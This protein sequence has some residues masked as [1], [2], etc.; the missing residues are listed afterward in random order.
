MSDTTPSTPKVDLLTRI[1]AVDLSTQRTDF[2]F[3]PMPE[4]HIVLG[5][6][7]P[8][9]QKAF[10]LGF[11]IAEEIVT[12]EQAIADAHKTHIDLH[13]SDAITNGACEEHHKRIEDLEQKVA[14]LTLIEESVAGLFTSMVLDEF[15]D[16]TDVADSFA[17]NEGFVVSKNPAT[18]KKRKHQAVVVGVRIVKSQPEHKNDASQSPEE[19]PTDPPTNDEE[20]VS[21]K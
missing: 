5:T 2:T 14:K 21:E 1:L 17:I 10:W 11:D 7:S 8:N 16:I 18:P 12:I 15:P 4:G 3:D 13:M 20:L 9:A 6:L 19:A